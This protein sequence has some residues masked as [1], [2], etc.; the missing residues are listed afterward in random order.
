MKAK[1]IFSIP[2]ILSYVF[3]LCTHFIDPN[4]H[5]DLHQCPNDPGLLSGGVYHPDFWVDRFCGWSDR[6]AV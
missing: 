6:K 5:W 2:N 3:I 1:E 4:V